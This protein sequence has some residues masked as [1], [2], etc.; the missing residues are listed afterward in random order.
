MS[1][2]DEATIASSE[3]YVYIAMISLMLNRLAPRKKSE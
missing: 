3:S 1:K 2:D